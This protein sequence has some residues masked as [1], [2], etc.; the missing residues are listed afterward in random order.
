MDC[1]CIT[2]LLNREGQS[3][4]IVKDVQVDDTLKVIVSHT[5]D[6]LYQDML[7]TCHLLDLVSCFTI[8]SAG[9]SSK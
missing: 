7:Q 6:I 1:N 9:T 8:V 2:I 3:L 5:G 4:P